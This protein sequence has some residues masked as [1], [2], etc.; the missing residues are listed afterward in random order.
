MQYLGFAL[1]PRFHGNRLPW[2]VVY[3][4]QLPFWDGVCTTGTVTYRTFAMLFWPDNA[5]VVVVTLVF[6]A[7]LL[8]WWNRKVIGIVRAVGLIRHAGCPLQNSYT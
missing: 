2:A 3:L 1:S 8:P 4:L 5:S 6:L 7:G